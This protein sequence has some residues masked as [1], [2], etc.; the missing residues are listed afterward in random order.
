MSQSKDAAA[1][2]ELIVGI[3][4]LQVCLVYGAV[5]GLIG[6]VRWCAGGP[7]LDLA[8][9][10]AVNRFTAL[11]HEDDAAA[12]AAREAAEDAGDDHYHPIKCLN[13]CKFLYEDDSPRQRARFEE[14]AR[15]RVEAN[16]PY[17]AW[18]G[19][20]AY[21]RG[22]RGNAYTRFL[23]ARFGDAATSSADQVEG[24]TTEAA[25]IIPWRSSSQGNRFGAKQFSVVTSSDLSMRDTL[26]KVAEVLRQIVS[27][28]S[29]GRAW[30]VIPSVTP[31]GQFPGAL[32]FEADGFFEP[33]H[34]PYLAVNGGSTSIVAEPAGARRKNG[35]GT[36][37]LTCTAAEDETSDAMLLLFEFRQGT[38]QMWMQR[39]SEVLVA[40][41]IASL[42]GAL[43]RDVQ[44][45]TPWHFGLGEWVTGQVVTIPGQGSFALMRSGH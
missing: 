6:V 43:P 20:L 38:Q 17:R 35:G 7:R 11:I 12:L 21:V 45:S 27:P 37:H 2:L 32:C 4:M 29:T 39:E 41:T 1:L 22:R 33:S 26:G 25:Q 23:I 28:V 24:R 19:A 31:S 14:Q 34:G 30:K 3:F 18:E 40:A 13:S 9:T 42:A 5:K 16:M 36:V 15:R 8:T 10:E 44:L